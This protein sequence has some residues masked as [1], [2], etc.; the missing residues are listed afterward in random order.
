MENED[1]L[2]KIFS[3]LRFYDLVNCAKVCRFWNHVTSFSF[4]DDLV[5]DWKRSLYLLHKHHKLKAIAP[6]QFHQ[7][8]LLWVRSLGLFV[9][10]RV[11]SDRYVVIITPFRHTIAYQFETNI[12]MSEWCRK[13][14]FHFYENI[15][16]KIIIVM[17]FQH[18]IDGTSFSLVIDLT[19]LSQIEISFK[20]HDCTQYVSHQKCKTCCAL[21]YFNLPDCNNKL[22]PLYTNDCIIFYDPVLNNFTSH[23]R[24]HSVMNLA[25]FATLTSQQQMFTTNDF[26]VF[27][28]EHTTIFVEPISKIVF[29]LFFK[30]KGNIFYSPSKQ[31]LILLRG[32]NQWQE[33]STFSTNSFAYTE[34]KSWQKF[35]LRSYFDY[36]GVQKAEYCDKS[37]SVLFLNGLFEMKIYYIKNLLI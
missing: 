12:L 36:D 23:D 14:V 18:K 17:H 33:L 31:R 5:G 26:F 28:S 20:L 2:F 9:Q 21:Q 6:L 16:R 10:F 8:N 15:H 11:K 4:S 3:F 35:K 7:N 24:T 37:Q 1:V 19:I 32:S 25:P 13:S 27:Y 30:I 29:K 34:L 22:K